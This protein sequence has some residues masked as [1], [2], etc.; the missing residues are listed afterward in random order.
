MGNVIKKL[1]ITS[2]IIV[3]FF[4]GSVV[5]VLTIDL[6]LIKEEKM[7]LYEV[8]SIIAN[9]FAVLIAVIAI[10]FTVL[11]LKSQKKQ[12]LNENFIKHEAEVLLDFRKKLGVAEKSIY[13]FIHDL[14]NIDKKYGFIPDTPPLIK[15]NDI[16][17]H[18]NMLVDLNNFYNSNQSIFRKH[19][20]EKKMECIS[21]L[22]QSAT[23]LPS[24][25]I[26]YYLIE[27]KDNYQVYRMEQRVLANILSFNFLAHNLHDIKPNKQ[28]TIDE[29]NKYNELDK[30]TELNRLKN[31]TSQELASLVFKLDELTIYVDST[32][33]ES[34]KIRSMRFFQKKQ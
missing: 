31:L 21:L 5:T 6:V 19:Q 1:K 16:K 3:A 26:N 29:M 9:L 20:L 15:Y 28:E 34:L 24:K 32:S 27:S 13:F 7:S 30:I 11:S 17:E 25:D 10:L 22:L 33:N 23:N 12:W 2:Y 14:L 18:F 8:I 4:I